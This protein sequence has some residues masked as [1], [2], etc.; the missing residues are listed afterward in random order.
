MRAASGAFW[1]AALLVVLAFPFFFVDVPPVLD[2]PNHLAR[3]FVLAHPDDP[4]LSRF[5]APHWVILPN[6]GFDLVG[7]ALL[8]QLPVHVAG[9]ILLYLSLIA[10]LLGVMAYSKAAFGKVTGWSFAAGAAAFNGVFFLGFMNFLLSLG[11]AFGAASLWM[12]L[13]RRSWLAAMLM[14]TL[15]SGV[16]FLCHIFGAALFALLI[17]SFEAERLWARGRAHK[18]Y[19]ATAALLAVTL[20]PALVLYLLSPVAAAGGAPG[21][22]EYWRKGWELFTPFMTYSKVLTLL[23]GA[24]LFGF[25]ILGLRGARY[26][27]GARLALAL[28]ALGYFFAP[29]T[30]K[31]GT[32]VDVRLALMLGLLLF[33]GIAPP[34][35][36]GRLAGF[37]LAALIVARSASVAMTWNSHG[38]YLSDLRAAMAEIPPGAK[39]L[40]AQGPAQ[41]VITDLY[42]MDS[43]MP[44]LLVIERRAFWPLL[45]ADAGQQPLI[46]RPPYDRMAQPLPS[47]TPDWGALQL[48][49]WRSDFDYVLLIAPPSPLSA[50]AGLVPL[51]AGQN[52]A[53]WR[54]AR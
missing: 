18:D 11:L 39:V 24:L 35:R 43:H 32:F 44:A 13:R 42:R 7:P 6:L 10:P 28:L 9:R 22:W 26:A 17:A 1:L 29:D 12:S 51:Y 52:T 34:P 20:A 21:A 16:I 25:L 38:A 50:P 41:I 46:V 54:V 48:K 27:P 2:Y 40:A 45:F 47:D 23:T 33:A 53:L 37:A 15:A 31:G 14:G 3:F 4:I 36:F 8:N 19:A 30:L 49:N 5:Y